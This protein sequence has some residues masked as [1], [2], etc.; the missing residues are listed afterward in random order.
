MLEKDSTAARLVEQQQI[1]D[2]LQQTISGLQFAAKREQV[3]LNTDRVCNHYQTAL[4]ALFVKLTAASQQL[5]QL[6]SSSK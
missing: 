3:L 2:F 1:V 4:A 6:K 5:S